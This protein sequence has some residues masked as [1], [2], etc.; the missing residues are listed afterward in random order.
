MTS[1]HGQTPFPPAHKT[2]WLVEKILEATPRKTYNLSGLHGSLLSLIIAHVFFRQQRA[3]LVIFDSEEKAACCYDDLTQLLTKKA[4]YYF[5]AADNER[6]NY[7]S[8]RQH[9]VEQIAQA[10][11][12]YI[13]ATYT[14]ALSQQVV[15]KEQV[16]AMRFVLKQGAPISRR[17]IL[18][19]L[20][21]HYEKTTAT[22]MPGEFSVRGGIIDVFPYNHTAPVRIEAFGDTIES[23]RTFNTDTQYSTHSHQTIVLFST[24]HAMET[25]HLTSFLSYFPHAGSMRWTSG[26]QEIEDSTPHNEAKP[27][28]PS[29]LAVPLADKKRFTTMVCGEAPGTSCA[30]QE[31][32]TWRYRAEKQPSFARD[33]QRMAAYL[34]SLQ[35]RDYTLYISS[36]SETHLQRLQVLFAEI[37]PTLSLTP[38]LRSL[39][40]G[41]INHEYQY[42]LFTTHGLF[43]GTYQHSQQRVTYHK[44]VHALKSLHELQIGDYVTHIDHGIGRFV[45]LKRTPQE[46]EVLCVLFK[47]NDVL[48][49][50]VQSL[51][52]LAKYASKEGTSVALA[53]LGSKEWAAKK[54]RAKK[55]LAEEVEALV[56]LYAKRKA[57]AGY[58]YPPDDSTQVVLEASFGHEDTPD[59]VQATRDIKRDMEAQYPMDRL[60]CGDVGF[61]KTEL[62][63]RAAAKAV[64]HGKQVVV[65]VPTTLLCFQHHRVFM[66]RMDAFGIRVDYVNRFR[67]T[68]EIK[69]LIQDAQSGKVEVLIG[70]HRVLNKD[71]VFKDLGL[72]I[73]DEE[74]RFGVKMKERLKEKKVHVDTLT[75]SATPIPRT[76]HF[77]LSGIRDVSLLQTPPPHRQAIHT[78]LAHTDAKVIKHAIAYEHN[79]GGQVFFVHNRIE[80][81]PFVERMVS[82]LF[83]Q[84]AIA[85][86]HGQMPS[87]TLED[88]M[89]GFLEKKYDILLSTNIVENGLDIPNANTILIH[90]AHFFGLSELH[91][92]RGRVGRSHQR[93]FCYL[94]CPPKEQLSHEARKRLATMEAFSAL[95]EGL[96]IALKDLET[97]GSGHLLGAEQSGFI[98]EMGFA[99]YHRLLDEAVEK[100]KTS[101]K[102]RAL[103]A[104]APQQKNPM[105]LALKKCAVEGEEILIIPPTY[106][107]EEGE[108]LRIYETLNQL[109]NE[110]A[111]QAY[112][113]RLRDRFGPLPPEINPITRLLRLRWLGTTCGFE[114]IVYKAQQMTCYFPTDNET[115]FA[116]TAFQ[117]VLFFVQQHPQRCQLVEHE[118]KGYLRLIGQINHAEAVSCLQQM[119]GDTT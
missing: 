77:S 97:R 22:T 6:S 83:P 114:K 70:T 91:Q 75:L 88:K 41:F 101:E 96:K 104:A 26:V 60:I 103:F 84:L 57:V 51:W 2:D 11:T 98:N 74:Q 79:R 48:Y 89:L 34:L 33:H 40:E 12:P 117:R 18:S 63:I 5:P 17:D 64:I 82:E 92:L 68:S 107:E 39:S 99:H 10:D 24:H 108:R 35:A 81:L 111:L 47:D 94:L 85:V 7:L 8:K 115:Y 45:G 4:V 3:H 27:S 9:V 43:D 110:E 23:L 72:L 62:A 15:Q 54:K 76:L 105:H 87:E 36:H 113:A 21:T 25:T 61:G 100:I 16:A 14:E 44:R 38:L 49:V 46:Q 30:G 116:T 78:V 52:K 20:G 71:F 69:Q 31:H 109:N 37:A 119:A 42:A 80:S 19:Y 53:K 59:Q 1:Q 106:V 102:Y 65:L 32:A 86:V 93:G 56:M 28:L 13:V 90:N 95:G 67:S 29:G 118:K 112:L 50:H 66:S 55:R 58:A 73:V